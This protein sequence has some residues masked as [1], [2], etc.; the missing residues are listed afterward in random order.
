[1]PVAE[2]P[3]VSMWYDER[4]QVLPACCSIPAVPGLT[5]VP[6][7]P[8]STASRGSSVVTRLSSERTAGRP[9]PMARSATS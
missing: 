4:G 5:P 6:L 9:M 3:G 1:M 2:L 7:T 8:P